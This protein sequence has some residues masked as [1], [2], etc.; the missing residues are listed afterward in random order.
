MSEYHLASIVIYLDIRGYREMRSKAEYLV[1][2]EVS[3]EACSSVILPY[4]GQGL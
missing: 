1:Q 2:D 4:A 3:C